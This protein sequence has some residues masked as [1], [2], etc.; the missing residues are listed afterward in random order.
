[1]LKTNV[2]QSEEGIHVIN[3]IRIRLIPVG[4]LCGRPT[5][6]IIS[7]LSHRLIHVG[8]AA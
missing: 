3:K 5:N 4:L 7:S 6:T 2:C 8:L 1:M